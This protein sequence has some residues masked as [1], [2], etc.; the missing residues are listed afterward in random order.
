MQRPGRSPTDGVAWRGEQAD[1]ADWR[2]DVGSRRTR[3]VVAVA[4]GGGPLARGEEEADHSAS[5]WKS[6]KEQC[7][8]YTHP[9]LSSA[10]AARRTAASTSSQS[11]FLA[12]HVHRLDQASR[13]KSAPR[14]VSSIGSDALP[15]QNRRGMRRSS[16]QCLNLA[17]ENLSPSKL[18]KMRTTV[19]RN[20][21]AAKR[22]ATRS[23]KE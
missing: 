14:H 13:V 8:K 6:L 15:G 17:E 23:R 12:S 20:P 18:R 19:R 7:A 9:L 5:V 4:W 21:P 2:R 16:A 10:P 11:S 22:G 1:E 3:L